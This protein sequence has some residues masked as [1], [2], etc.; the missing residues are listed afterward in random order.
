[1]YQGFTTAKPHV[2][3]ALPVEVRAEVSRMAMKWPHADSF[4]TVVTSDGAYG[5]VVSANEQVLEVS[6]VEAVSA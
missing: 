3:S 2:D 1:M 5:I 4:D 6:A